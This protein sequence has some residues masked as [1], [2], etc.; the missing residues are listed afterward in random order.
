M[1][2]L[3]MWLVA[4]S[5]PSRTWLASAQ[6][7]RNGFYFFLDKKVAKNQVRKEASLRT[8]PLRRRADKNHGPGPFAAVSRKGLRFWQNYQCPLPTLKP[9]VLSALARSLFSDGLLTRSCSFARWPLLCVVTN[10]MWGGGV[11]PQG[12][13]RW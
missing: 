6:L 11:R 4:L 5:G 9:S 8:G 7:P 1:C 12:Y 13:G 3:I 10:K 2:T